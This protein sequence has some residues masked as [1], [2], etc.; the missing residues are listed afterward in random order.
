M[1]ISTGVINEASKKL[2]T[3]IRLKLQEMRKK[4]HSGHGIKPIIDLD[5]CQSISSN[6]ENPIIWCM[7][8]RFTLAGFGQRND[9]NRKVD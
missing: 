8:I 4:Q 3:T 9:I 2:F 6:S 1:F 5:T 7:A